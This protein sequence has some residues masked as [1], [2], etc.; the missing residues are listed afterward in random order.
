MASRVE[1]AKVSELSEGEMKPV[2]VG[3]RTVVLFNIGG[4]LFAI[5]DECTHAGC[6]LS[7]GTLDGDEL[8]CV[9]HGS[10][11]NV[12]TGDVVQGPADEP[13]PTYPVHSE[14]DTVYTEVG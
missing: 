10:V 14:G 7:D 8:E 2:A 13:V 12:K 3:D 4:E 1:V 6:S 9:C 5:D 11:F